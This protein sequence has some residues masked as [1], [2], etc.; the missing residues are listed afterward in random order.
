MEVT[1]RVV[2]P[3]GGPVADARVA[4]L[5]HHYRR[6]QRPEGTYFAA[7][8]ATT[9][10]LWGQGKTDRDGRFRLSGPA[11]SPSR[12]SVGASLVSSAPGHSLVLHELDHAAL[13]QD[14]VVRLGPERVVRG[15]LIDLQGQPAAGVAV[16]AL[17]PSPPFARLWFD[18]PLEDLLPFWPAPATTDDKGR[19]LLR[20]LGPDKV[21][22]ETR[23][24]R[25]APQH[26]DADTTSP[27]GEGSVTLSL[28][29]ARKL[30]G[31]VVLAD[32]GP[33]AGVR[34]VVISGDDPFGMGYQ[35]VEGHT[36]GRG[37]FSLNVFPGES[38]RIVVRPQDGSAYLGLSKVVSWA[39]V[40]RPGINLSLRRG[41]VVRGKVTEAPSGRPAAGARVQYRPRQN[42][43]PHYQPERTAGDL[44]ENL[45]TAITGAA[46]EFQLAVPPGPGHLLVTGPTLDY[47]HVV[48]SWGELEY[49]K[50]GGMRWYPDAL[51]PL[52]LKPDAEGAE[53]KATVRRGVT[54]TGRVLGPDGKPVGR[55]RVLCRSYIPTGFQ[56]WQRANVLEGAGGRFELPG[57]DPEKEFDLWFFDPKNGLGSAA[58]LSGKQAGGD[59]VTVRLG[60]CGSA[61]VRY[62]GPDGAPLASPPTPLQIVVTPGAAVLVH[63]V[64]FDDDDQKDL[65]ADWVNVEALGAGGHEG[66]RADDKGRVTFPA[67]IP[68]ATYRL[69]MPGGDAERVRTKGMPTKDFTVR[70]G[71]TVTLPDITW[72]KAR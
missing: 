36:D 2:G 53:V 17:W 63:Q 45:A 29:G 39:Q 58:R 16:R 27:G 15:R 22:I 28:V 38:L 6:S 19:F 50:P 57:C 48:T 1:G 13:R 5:V 59:P 68:G 20:G 8:L 14:V 12:P 41:T 21:R 18:R 9:T 3:D 47:V 37:L 25:F 64:G 32:G 35:K 70:P 56:W 34:L 40:A 55:F 42:N 44:E 49:G 43:N 11:Y 71:E 62:V 61:V 66:L 33:A 65:E 7:G 72:P 23:H 24:A 51:V 31:R 10:E 67:L 52:D 69:L 60:R 46:G 26:L 4:A 54:L 30:R